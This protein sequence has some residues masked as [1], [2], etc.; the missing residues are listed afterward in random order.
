M[1]DGNVHDLADGREHGAECRV[2]HVPGKISD[3]D[4]TT[5]YLVCSE[6]GLVSCLTSG[7][8]VLLAV[9]W[10]NTVLAVGTER[11][12]VYI[13]SSK[14]RRSCQYDLQTGDPETDQTGQIRRSQTAEGPERP[15]AAV[16]DAH[17]ERSGRTVQGCFWP[18]QR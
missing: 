15:G 2:V 13:V 7:H 10:D 11:L 14:V 18:H 17:S 1:D 16:K 6:V 4:A 3:P 12:Y 8:G 5:V 9:E